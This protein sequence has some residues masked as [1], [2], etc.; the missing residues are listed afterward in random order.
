MST[1]DGRAMA[2]ALAGGLPAVA[3]AI[4]ATSQTSWSPATRWTVDAFVVVWWFALAVRLRTHVGRPV[5]TLSNLLA[6]LRE[7]DYSTRARLDDGLDPADP[8]QGAMREANAL[9]DVLFEQRLGAVDATTLLRKVMEQA[10]VAVIAFDAEGQLDLAND[11]AERLLGAPFERLRRRTAD[12]VGLSGCLEGPTPRLLDPGLFGGGGRWELR[13][14][15]FRQRG[16]P[17][18][19]L[20]LTDLSQ[21]LQEEERTA[22]KRLIRVISHEINNSLAPI[23]SIA[24]SLHDRTRAN[25]HD[26]PEWTQD[27]QDGLTVIADRSEALSRFIGAHARLARLPEP[28]L[29]PTKVGPWV[30]RVAALETRLSV[31]V[32]P[33]PDV[34][35]D[36]DSD[37]LDQLLINLVTNAADAATEAGGG[38]ELGW[39]THD[40]A[41]E[42][43]VRDEGPGLPPRAN[44]F[45]PLFSTKP[46]GSGIGLALAR[47][48]ALTHGGRLTLEDRD[49]GPGCIARVRLPRATG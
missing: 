43:W 33:G 34:T 20:V 39:S 19:L 18:Q 35:L 15:Q 7:G 37:Q 26:D 17:H 25:T 16:Q 48:I 29:A 36:A 3:L 24:Q 45:V 31:A 4:H 49:D 38:V 28:T 10:N 11:A 27:L 30:R 14:A 12:D 21:A 41:V 1:H 9:A 23:S 47:Q 13:R 6:G 32:R 44:L 8:M 2:L 42:V 46:G 5:Q 22:W 40:D